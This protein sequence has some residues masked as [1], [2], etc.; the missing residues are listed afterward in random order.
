MTDQAT[1]AQRETQGAAARG[2]DRRSWTAPDTAP[3]VPAVV[4]GGRPTHGEL[5]G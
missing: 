2:A 1:T 4:S 3:G 5:A